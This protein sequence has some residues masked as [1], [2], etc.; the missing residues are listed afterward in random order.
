MRPGSSSHELAAWNLPGSC[1]VQG[2][3]LSWTDGWNGTS[4]TEESRSDAKLLSHADHDARHQGVLGRTAPGRGGA[5]YSRRSHRL[6]Q[7]ET[8]TLEAPDLIA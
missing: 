7:E 6:G 5:A 1:P 4:E 8:S 3:F 2:R